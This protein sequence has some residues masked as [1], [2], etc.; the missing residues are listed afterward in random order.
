[1]IKE[2]EAGMPT[3][4]VCR[5]HGLSQ[6]TFYK[7]KSKYGGMEVSD[8]AKA[9]SALAE[10]GDKAEPDTLLSLITRIDIAPGRL[11]LQL[12][13]DAL[14]EAVG[15]DSCRVAEDALFATFPFRLRKRG[16]DLPYHESAVRHGTPPSDRFR[17]K[18]AAAEWAGLGRARLQHAVT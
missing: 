16:V 4:E 14:A 9:A 17:R 18:P 10:I 6:G 5:K 13:A 11:D 1:M 8:A 3:A 15:A 2:Q 7:F 12:N